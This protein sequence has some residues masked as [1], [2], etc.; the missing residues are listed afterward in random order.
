MG[1]GRKRNDEGRRKEKEGVRK[2]WRK[3]DRKK[4]LE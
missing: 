2:K 4:E 1:G 3:E